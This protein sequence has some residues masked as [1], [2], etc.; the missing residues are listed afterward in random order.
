[1]NASDRPIPPDNPHPMNR[2]QHLSQVPLLVFVFLLS[3]CHKEEV[4]DVP[5][6]VPHV[7]SVTLGIEHHM[8]GV[9]LA[10]DTL[11][12]Y[13]VA[14][15][16]YSVSRLQYYLSEIVLQGTGSTPNDTIHGP[17]YVDGN[18]SFALGIMTAGTYSGATLLLGLPPSINLTGGL[19]NTLENLNMAWPDPM[20]GGYHFIKFEGHFMNADIPT[21]FAMHV[22][23]NAYL[24]HAELDQPLILDG[25]SGTLVMRFN[26]NEL[27]RTPHTYDLATGNYSM[28]S[29]ALMGQL[30]DNAADA[31]T[32]EYRP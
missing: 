11:L 12:Y 20:G 31:F 7:E 27:F 18:R 32:I 29:M 5:L 10:N 17:Y 8:D 2:Y 16:N 9:D 22:G 3:A 19:P 28:G 15:H 25:R 26:L 24:P 1:M 4:E 23:G 6:V 14:G 13:T 30:R 21:G